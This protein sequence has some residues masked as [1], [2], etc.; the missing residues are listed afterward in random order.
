VREK[1]R[2]SIGNQ[3]FHLGQRSEKFSGRDMELYRSELNPSSFD[4]EE[5]WR[6]GLHGKMTALKNG[7]FTAENDRKS[8]YDMQG[9]RAGSHFLTFHRLR[10]P[11]FS[12][13]AVI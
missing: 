7:V 11:L 5:L 10:L 12:R 6:Q 13:H 8:R 2:Q 3:N 4:C 9:C 1:E